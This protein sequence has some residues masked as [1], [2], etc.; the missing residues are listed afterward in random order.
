MTRTLWFGSTVCVIALAL[1]CSKHSTA[2]ASPTPA[3]VAS[4]QAGADGSTLKVSAP[5]PV[6]PVNGVQLPTGETTTLVINNAAPTFVTNIDLQYEFEVLNAAGARVFTG[7]VNGGGDGTTRITVAADLEG[8]QTYRW[9]ARAVFGNAVGPWP[10]SFATFVAPIN[11]GYIRGN[12]LYDPLI[13]GK[14]VGEVHGPV[15]FIPGVGVKLLGWTSYISYEL[16]QTLLEGEYSLIVTNMPANTK[17]GKQKVM[18]M[19]QG[20]SDIIENDRRMT[21]EKRGDPAGIIAW[22][23]LT[24][25][26]RIETEGAERTFYNFQASQEYFFQTSWRDNFFDVLIKEGGVSGNP[27]YDRGKHWK[28]DPYN[29]N[30][31]VIY[32]GSPVGRSGDSAASI[33]NTIYRQIWVSS[34]PRPAFAK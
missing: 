2:P 14:T 19:A 29:P 12:E 16:P 3:D 10:G 34:R 13:N 28:G 25:H 26:D 5:T 15:Q 33:E 4:G 23:L 17:G 30:P 11:E 9:R 6:S 8:D 7:K 1:A 27:I 31:H 32:V 21:V 18:A 22:R 24:H 20:Y